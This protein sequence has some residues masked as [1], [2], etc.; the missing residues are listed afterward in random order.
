M[1]KKKL[2]RLEREFSRSHNDS[3]RINVKTGTALH[4]EISDMLSKRKMIKN[5]KTMGYF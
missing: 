3:I 2:L 4:A 1:S 5:I